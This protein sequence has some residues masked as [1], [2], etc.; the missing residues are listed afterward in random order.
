MKKVFFI[1]YPFPPAGGS[2]VNRT[3]SF[4]KYLVRYGWHI[5]VLTVQNGKH[6]VFDDSLLKSI[7]KEVEVYR[8]FTLESIFKKFNNRGQRN[9]LHSNSVGKQNGLFKRVWDRIYSIFGEVIG[10]PDSHGLWV[11]FAVAAGMKIM[12]RN[13]IDIIYS[14]NPTF[15]DGIVGMLIANIL[16]KPLVSDFRDAWISNPVL[17]AKR[18]Y[19]KKK[20]EKF[21]EGCVISSSS[22]IISTTKY[23]T[24]DFVSRYPNVCATKFATIM[25]GYDCEEFEFNK[26]NIMFSEKFTIVYAG[27]LSQE[28]SPKIILEVISELLAEHPDLNTKIELYFIGECGLFEDGASIDDYLSQYNLGHITKITGWLPKIETKKHLLRANLLLLIVGTVPNDK[29]NTYGLTSK[30]FEYAMTGNP[31]LTIA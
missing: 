17:E 25:N 15:C 5:S 19:L 26:T 7:P 16:H 3:L 9:K 13:D 30:V 18:N 21:L 2:D 14:T 28:R 1:A 20:I 11:P 22:K 23:I 29:K 31:I 10:I 6:S 8:V 4:L 27:R 12:R 24:A